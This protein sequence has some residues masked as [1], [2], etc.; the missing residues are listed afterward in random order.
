MFF[1]YMQIQKPTLQQTQRRE[2]MKQTSPGTLYFFI[3]IPV[4]QSITHRESPPQVATKRLPL[5]PP[6]HTGEHTLL[7]N[8]KPLILIIYKPLGVQSLNLVQYRWNLAAAG[9]RRPTAGWRSPPGCPV[10]CGTGGREEASD[11]RAA[12][13][14]THGQRRKRNGEMSEWWRRLDFKDWSTDIK[15]SHKHCQHAKHQ[16]LESFHVCHLS[17][18]RQHTKMS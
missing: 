5:P 9:R 6:D 18:A 4:S 15:H 7:A 16:Q 8:V 3:T 12:G 10:Y 17:L 2:L 1:L 14:W 13:G 11:A